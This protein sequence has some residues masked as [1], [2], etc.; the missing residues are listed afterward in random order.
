[1]EKKGKERSKVS[2]LFKVLGVAL[3]PMILLVVF[4]VLAI[5]SVGMK[6]AENGSA[7]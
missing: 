3:L 5:R 7:N 2:L 4:A 1:M 6:V